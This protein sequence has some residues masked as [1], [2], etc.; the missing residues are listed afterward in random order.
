[1]EVVIAP[2]RMEIVDI[3]G[4][5]TCKMLSTV[6]GYKYLVDISLL[7]LVPLLY[8]GSACSSQSTVVYQCWVKC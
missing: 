1:M 8:L 7:S 3:N 4:D 6:S 2:S 5:G